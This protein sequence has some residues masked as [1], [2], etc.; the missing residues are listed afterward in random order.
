MSEGSV[1]LF[2]CDPI[3]WNYHGSFEKAIHDYIHRVFPNVDIEHDIRFDKEAAKNHLSM[4]E[5]RFPLGMKAKER[6]FHKRHFD[7]FK[8]TMNG[9]FHYISPE[10]V[11]FFCYIEEPKHLK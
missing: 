2:F 1:C 4:M 7:K 11:M 9:K 3:V 5:W 8:R 6:R 10:P